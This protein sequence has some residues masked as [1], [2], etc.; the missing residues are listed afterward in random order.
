MRNLK[1]I[2][3]LV[4]AL[5]MTLSLM[6]IASAAT[7]NDSDS[8][9]PNYAEA[10]EV[11]SGLGVI[12]GGD[13]GNYYPTLTL[14][15][16]AAAKIITYLLLTKE[17]GD[18]LETSSNPFADVA[19]G[20]WAAGS[21]AYCASRGIIT[22]DGTNF[23]PNVAVNGYQFAKMLLGAI[24]VE[25]EFSGT[26]AW[27]LNVAL[28][29]KKAGLL[30]GLEKV[31]LSANLT[32]EQ[33]A[34]MAFNA[35]NYSA[36]GNT[37]VYV[38]TD[39]TGKVLYQGAN[40]DT[41]YLL[42]AL[43]DGATLS[44]DTVATG[45]LGATV[46]DMSKST[47]EDDFGRQSVTYTNGKTGK[48][49]VT[50]ATLES[51]PALTYETATTYGKVV[52]DL[53]YTKVADEVTLNIRVDGAAATTV[54]ANRTNKTV[55]GGQGT[56]VEVYAAGEDTYDVIVVNTYATQLASSDI[57]KAVAATA[58]TDAQAAYITID[59]MNYETSAFVKNDVVLYTKTASKIVN[60]VKAN[61]ISG[62]VTATA[63]GYFRVD[64]A[65]KVL[66]ANSGL[67]I[68]SGELTISS[69]TAKTFYLDNNG[70]VI[71]VVRGET[72]AP[73]T[74]YAYVI[75]TAAK[76]TTIN[77][78][79][80]NLFDE[81]SSQTAAAQARVIDLA[82]GVIKVVNL[83]V[84]KNTAGKWV[85][86]T[87]T[88]AASTVAVEDGKTPYTGNSLYSYVEQEDGTYVLVAT[89]AGQN[90]TVK[91]GQAS[92]ANQ[93]FANSS[94]VLTVVEYVTKD[95][96][97]V[98][99]AVT[100]TTGIANFPATAVSYTGALVIAD[101]GIVSSI[102]VVK[103]KGAVVE[104]LPYAVYAGEGETDADGTKHAFY[105]GGELV[106]YY[107]DKTFTAPTK[108]DVVQLTVADGVV[109]KAEAVKA[110][111]EEV[112]VTFVDASFFI[113]GGTPYYFADSYEVVDANDDYATAEIEVGDVVTV[114]GAADEVEFVAIV[115]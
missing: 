41:A 101:K 5:M 63:N 84:V 72:A 76:V 115:G 109:S 19:S 44:Y 66:A 108:G 28:A 11:I 102:T 90:V 24:G 96:N 99:A 100:T 95:N 110:V 38:V 26:S 85:Y 30:S 97:I 89:E 1:K 12:N 81:S 14:N 106:E 86:A 31:S 60:V 47:V 13:G 65:Q 43:K 103:E 15:R 62:Y 8:I 34:Q 52:S 49:K 36:E 70:N 2:L 10:V 91:K 59:G 16:D 27:E 58:T 39:S 33:A 87:A 18:T 40:S 21:I 23:Y 71:Y 64:G 37:S 25:G 29:A 98:S 78:A 73:D 77:N 105:V 94:T 88:G 92:V 69:T 57:H 45:S 9:N 74:H 20:N 22:G 114:F 42:F 51:D 46:Y 93:L 50:Y 55:L 7:F 111:A 6:G 3:A 56:L 83:A 17:Y 80:S 53:G 104:A 35:L 75:E 48:D 79:G 82:T 112:E 113:A 4:L 107:A 32:R 54:A 67:T 68:G 61:Y